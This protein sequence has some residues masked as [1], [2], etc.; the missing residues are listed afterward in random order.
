MAEL[1]QRAAKQ[2]RATVGWLLEVLDEAT[3]GNGMIV[4]MRMDDGWRVAHDVQGGWAVSRPTL[5]AALTRA[6]LLA[7]EKPGTY[8]PWKT[9][10]ES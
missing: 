10:V 9:E 7:R 2:S 1:E 8:E 4:I 5:I 6:A 3:R